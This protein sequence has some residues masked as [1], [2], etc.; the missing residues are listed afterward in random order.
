MTVRRARGGETVRVPG[1]TG[2]LVVATPNLSLEGLDLAL[3]TGGNATATVAVSE[4]GSDALRAPPG[5][6]AIGT[7][8]IQHSVSADRVD[9]VTLWASV[10][11]EYLENASI[12]PDDLVLYRLSEGQWN[13]L[14]TSVV[15]ESEEAIRYVL[16]GFAFGV[17]ARALRVLARAGGR[18]RP[19]DGRDPTHDGVAGRPPDRTRDGDGG[20]G[21]GRR[22]AR[23][24]APRNDR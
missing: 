10:D 14:E 8:R 19:G 5:V 1:Y 15:N 3:A 9:G 18:E 20:R 11:R 13:A 7:V 17:A 4:R 6:E 23:R 2:D 12:A 16:V 22:L 21:S 24:V